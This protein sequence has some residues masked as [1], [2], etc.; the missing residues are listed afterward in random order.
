MKIAS[1]S[2]P[3]GI[4]DYLL[5]TAKLVLFTTVV[6]LVGGFAYGWWKGVQ[7][8]FVFNLIIVLGQTW[9]SR[10]DIADFIRGKSS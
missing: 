2:L 8:W 7:I 10:Q 6:A 9:A 5:L 4:R 1:K 3:A